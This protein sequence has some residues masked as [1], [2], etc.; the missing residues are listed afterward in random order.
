MSFNWDYRCTPNSSVE[1][2]GDARGFDFEWS[3]PRPLSSRSS[4]RKQS[5]LVNMKSGTCPNLFA[6]YPCL[7]DRINRNFIQSGIE[8]GVYLESLPVA[9]TLEVPVTLLLQSGNA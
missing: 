6:P 1:R 7:S 4:S 5:C 8:G 3:D 2:T 9:A